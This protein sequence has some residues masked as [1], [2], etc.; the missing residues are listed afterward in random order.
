MGV[1]KEMN[2][3]NVML[4]SKYLNI[5]SLFID[6]ELYLLYFIAEVEGVAD[7]VHVAENG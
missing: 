3:S 6:N 7:G 2:I 4:I 5:A 1:I